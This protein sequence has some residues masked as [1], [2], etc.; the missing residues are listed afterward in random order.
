MS[1]VWT[2]PRG[3]RVQSLERP[4]TEEPIVPPVERGHTLSAVIAV[5]AGVDRMT[6][7][8]QR[9]LGR[10]RLA[11]ADCLSEVAHRAAAIAHGTPR[12]NDDLRLPRPLAQ[13]IQQ[14]QRRALALAR[15]GGGGDESRRAASI[16]FVASAVIELLF[17]EAVERGD[18]RAL[19]SDAAAAV[20]VSRGAANLLVFIRG[21]QAISVAQLPPESAIAQV[22]DLLVELGPAEGVSLWRV[23][24]QGRLECLADA[25]EAARTR[26]L[27]DAARVVLDSG[28][29]V[30]ARSGSHVRGALVT[31]WDD[32]HAALVGR[33]R[34][35]VTGRLLVYLA[36]AA[37]A[38]SPVLEREMLFERKA[39]RELAL[40][41]ASERWGTRLAC[42]LHDGP[43]QEVVALADDLR[44]A[45]SQVA[46]LLGGSERD[47]VAGRFDDLEARLASLDRSLRDISHA[48]RA[49]SALEEPLE[50]A[51]QREAEVFARNGAVMV[52]FAS[53]GDVS[54]L[55]SSQKIALF[56][57]VQ[58]ALANTRKHSEATRADVCLRATDG[59]VSVSVSDD[60]NG[61]D[62]E[63]AKR[64]GRLGLSGVTERVRLLGGDIEIRSR[65]GQGTCIRA[66]LPRWTQD[67][68]SD[69]PA[70]VY[71]V[72]P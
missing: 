15:G 7:E 45:R 57:V 20:G 25:G 47:L 14:A 51:L 27:R 18:A 28:N 11:T 66:T 67:G 62:P 69:D 39:S 9:M 41:S 31:R 60:G 38:L 65:P 54:T 61:F 23:S 70:T 52:S 36:E 19:V 33:A 21:V 48:M 4:G 3:P 58:E 24:N 12:R 55:T 13:R 22:L 16:E 56:R 37:A 59:Y 64:K 50:Q 43:L 6:P 1:L 30:D 34:P 35:E 63:R 17:A 5:V 40:V 32:P 2:D 8:P 71:A 46:S 42:D 68:T 10:D 26:R 44:L 72:T 53:E 29:P 49:T